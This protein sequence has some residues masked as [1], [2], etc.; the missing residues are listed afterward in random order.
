M[1]DPLG[2]RIIDEP[3]P[4][5]LQKLALP[6]LIVFLLGNFFMPWGW[7]LI[8]ANAVALN[9]PQRNREIA[10]SLA[11]IGIYFAATAVLDRLIA[12][13]MLDGY[14]AGYLFVA[15]VGGALVLVAMAYVSQE[16]TWQ[17][18]RYL[19]QGA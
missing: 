12:A 19:Q 10:L 5:P 3:R 7:L 17:L 6:P 1:S 14:A 2:Y 4:G 8:A 16:E 11:P 9:G 15:C 13:G 18:R